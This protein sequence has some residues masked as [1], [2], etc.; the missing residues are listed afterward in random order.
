MH[1][2]RAVLKHEPFWNMFQIATVYHSEKCAILKL[3]SDWHCANFVI[4]R[5]DNIVSLT[6]VLGT[7]PP[8]RFFNSFFSPIN[9]AKCFQVIISA[10]FTHLLKYT[11]EI[12]GCRLY[13]GSHQKE[14][15]RGPGLVKS[16]DFNF[17][18]K[19]PCF[20]DFL[21]KNWFLLIFTYIFNVSKFPRVRWLHD[22]TVTSYEVQWYS[23][24]YQWIEEVHTYTLVANRGSSVPYRK[25]REGVATTPLR[26]TCY[27][28]YL[29]RTRVN[30]LR[31]K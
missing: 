6:L 31:L 1:G 10:S 7:P 26:R 29:R 27:K 13:M 30:T 28:K 11:G 12:R 14:W 15:Q 17:P 19:I 5:A 4:S 16:Q 22:V 2:L 8:V 23:F 9:C 18:A 25:S 3:V 20:Y 21:A 24:W